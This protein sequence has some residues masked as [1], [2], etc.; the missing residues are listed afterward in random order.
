[1]EYT[2]EKSIWTEAD[3]DTMNWH[4]VQIY[5][6]AMKGDL[7]FDIDYIF[8]W[9][10]P[11]VKGC[12]FTFWIAPCTLVFKQIR[13]L[14][15]D[16]DVVRSDA[17]QI[18][19]IERSGDRWTIV[20]RNGDISFV[21]EG[22]EQFVRQQPT[23]QYRHFIGIERGGYTLERI[24]DQPNHYL[25][26]EEYITRR[27]KEAE[28]YGYAKKRRQKKLDME[29]LEERRLNGEIDTAEFLQLKKE[30]LMAIDGYSY[31][32]KGTIFESS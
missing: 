8:K 30:M 1:M 23:F 32:L 12:M 28:L 3:F 13:N 6:M 22:Y 2:L 7:E 25:Q 26:H 16:L 24:T 27:K 18:D 15:F 5:E 20:T 29:A 17:F 14:R 9:N 19:Y 11:E 31:W 4:D 10:E 21:S